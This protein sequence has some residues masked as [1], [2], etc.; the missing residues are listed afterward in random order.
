MSR[1]GE[2][3]VAHTLRTTAPARRLYDL[4]AR[5]EHWPAV[6]EPT[7]HVQVLERGRGTERFRIWARVGGRVKT[8]TSRRT[9]DP[10][11]LRVTFRQELTQPPIASMGGSWEFRGDGDGTEVVLTHDFAAVDEAALPGLR[12]ALD[13]NSEKELAALATLAERRQPPEELVFTFEDTLRVPSGDEAYAFIERSDLWQERLP[14]VR[15]VTLTEEAAG[16]GPSETQD[17]TVQDM[18]MET[19]TTDGGTHTTRSIRLCVPGKS[20][21]YKQL[22]PPALLSGH[23]GAWLFGEDTVT[24]RHTVAIDPARVEEVLGRGGTVADARAHLR[25]VLGAN[26]RATLRHAAAAAGPAS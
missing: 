12:E 24:A 7:V 3:R 22:V 5:V 20:I 16:T 2:H 23:C 25:E 19:V 26:S 18:T 8:W 14:H 15:K 11:A 1:P 4:V 10:D 6:F 21:V 13:A 9:L 17:M